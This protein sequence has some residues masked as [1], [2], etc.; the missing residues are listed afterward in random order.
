MD[1]ELKDLILEEK[2]AFHD[3]RNKSDRRF[4]DLELKIG[5]SAFPGGP[6]D[7]ESETEQAKEYRQAFCN[8]L[9]KGRDGLSGNFLNALSVGSNPDGGYWIPQTISQKII[10]RL[11]ETSPMRKIANVETIETDEL[12]LPKDTDEAEA[13]GWVGEIGSRNDTDTPEI[14][15]HKI[16]LHELYAQPKSTQKLLDMKA[17]LDIEAWL[18]D[19][20]SKKIRRTENTAFITGNGVAKP[21]GITTYTTV[22]TADD[23]RAWGQLQHV[24][25]GANGDFLGAGSDPADCL[26]DVVFSLKEDYL[27]NAAWAMQ[28]ATLARIAKIKDSDGNYLLGTAKLQDKTPFEL[29]GFPVYLFSDM[30]AYSSTG[31]LAAAFG[32]F[33]EAY[34]IVDHK[35]G[36]SILRDPFTSKPYVKFYTVKYCGGDVVNFDALKFLKFSAS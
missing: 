30:P 5:R 29:L 27:Q 20:I 8:Y 15:I 33:R 13:G 18:I 17:I 26:L 24:I 1:S 10:Q 35:K 9:I 22:T 32:D 34:T 21:R 25:T 19:K 2:K 4:E 3:F 16:P 11:F 6:V 14:G 28:R 12:E 7:F 23:S 36:I 31:A